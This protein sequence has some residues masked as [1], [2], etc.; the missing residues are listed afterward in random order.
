[1]YYS[2]PL[3]SLRFSLAQIGDPS[4][5]IASHP[6]LQCPT[7]LAAY[8]LPDLR[9]QEKQVLRRVQG[10][11]EKVQNLASSLEQQQMLLQNTASLAD[12]GQLHPP[13]PAPQ[14]SSS[15]TAH[16]SSPAGRE[17]ADGDPSVPKAHSHALALLGVTEYAQ[18]GIVGWDGFNKT[19]R[20]R[21]K[22]KMSSQAKG[23]LAWGADD[24]LRLAL[25][26]LGRWPPPDYNPDQGKQLA[27]AE[28]HDEPNSVQETGP[29][30]SSTVQV[31]ESLSSEVDGDGD[32]I[33]AD[34]PMDE[35][36][37]VGA[38]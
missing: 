12:A 28:M 10:R 7:A 27:D 38:E 37:S 24:T 35:D 30:S 5:Q 8:P 2:S 26:G 14:D 19:Q 32:L 29:A 18:A 21:C 25:Q 33:S 1:M 15:E 3:P 22:Q 4:I 6:R 36:P 11:R 16:A 23:V 9:A 34:Q 13:R 17:E 31:G 20:Q